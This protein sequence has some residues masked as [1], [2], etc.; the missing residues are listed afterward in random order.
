[1]NEM[2]QHHAHKG[3]LWIGITILIGSSFV[4]FS[5]FKTVQ[6]IFNLIFN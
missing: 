3:C 4:G 5:L 2:V 1:M 6:F